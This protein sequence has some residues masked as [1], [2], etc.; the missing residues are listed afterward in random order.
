MATLYVRK[1]G[2][3]FGPLEVE[4]VAE[5]LTGGQIGPQDEVSKDGREWYPVEKAARP[6]L[7]AAGMSASPSAPVAAPPSPRS[8]GPPPMPRTAATA[9]SPRPVAVPTATSP[10]PAGNVVATV[11]PVWVS[12]HSD[13]G[14]LAAPDPFGRGP[15]SATI[16]APLYAP[17]ILTVLRIML[18]FSGLLYAAVCLN[19]GFIILV[20]TGGVEG[21]NAGHLMGSFMT[22]GTLIVGALALDLAVGVVLLV[23][24]ANAHARL[25]V[26]QPRHLT[27]DFSTWA[28]TYFLPVVTVFRTA[29][30]QGR[31]WNA[32]EAGN[33]QTGLRESK[34][35]IVIE[36]MVMRGSV[37]AT[38]LA[39]GL[40]LLWVTNL[41]VAE[42]SYDTTPTAGIVF[43]VLVFVAAVASAASMFG[44]YVYV[45]VVHRNLLATQDADEEPPAGSSGNVS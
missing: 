8:K 7:A 10:Q 27:K 1:D 14:S 11:I 13:G 42:R 44:H 40:A 28:I 19:Q 18:I 36:G 21:L 23:W 20:V 6:I 30:L 37:W 4:K 32:A 9:S 12:D 3:V 2:K 38:Y 29:D 17:A 39:A 33:R 16:D 24:L 26:L 45:G 5:A 34:P 15:V 31:I 35:A 22:Q 25:R 43:F 41:S